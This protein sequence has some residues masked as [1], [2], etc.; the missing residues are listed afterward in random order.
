MHRHYFLEKFCQ[1]ISL[2]HKL[3]E[4]LCPNAEM[5]GVSQAISLGVYALTIHV[6]MFNAA[7][8]R[9]DIA[10]ET[11]GSFENWCTSAFVRLK[12]KANGRSPA[13]VG[14]TSQGRPFCMPMYSVTLPTVPLSTGDM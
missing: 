6:R 8:M 5:L 12:W 3:V 14:H 4:F 1:K 10:I 11:L 7:P 13:V 9:P 2:W